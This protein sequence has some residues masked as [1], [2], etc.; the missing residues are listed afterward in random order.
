MQTLHHRSD[1]V[2][3]AEWSDV[4]TVTN[5]LTWNTI[6]GWSDMHTVTR[7]FHMG[8]RHQRKGLTWDVITRRSDEEH[9]HRKVG[10]GTL[11]PDNLTWHTIKIRSDM[12][13]YH[14]LGLT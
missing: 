7:R 1:R 6:T 5:V 13:H 2:A 9:H 11:S 8:Y 3:V 14:H 10:H 12:A 4:D